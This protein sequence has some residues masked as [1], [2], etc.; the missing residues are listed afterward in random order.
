MLTRLAHTHSLINIWK[1]HR[2]IAIPSEMFDYCFF[3]WG[4]KISLTIALFERLCQ[5]L[6]PIQCKIG[7]LK[8]ETETERDRQRQSERERERENWREIEKV[9]EM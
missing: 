3:N 8:I 5:V 6:C 2:N 7:Y 4:L 9:R 1:H